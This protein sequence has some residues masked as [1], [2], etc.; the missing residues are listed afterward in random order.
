MTFPSK[1][2]GEFRH[3]QLGQVKDALSAQADRLEVD[4]ENRKKAVLG[5][6]KLYST[7]RI[8]ADYISVPLSIIIGNP[9]IENFF[10]IKDT[11]TRNDAEFIQFLKDNLGKIYNVDAQQYNNDRADLIKEKV[12]FL[13]CS[14]LT[15]AFAMLKYK[16]YKFHIFNELFN[17][18]LNAV[19]TKTKISYLSL[20]ND[21]IIQNEISPLKISI[22]KPDALNKLTD[23]YFNAN[24]KIFISYILI[25][26]RLIFMQSSVGHKIPIRNKYVEDIK[27][28]LIPPNKEINSP[29]VLNILIS[30]VLKIDCNIP[31]PK[32]I[33][34]YSIT[35]E[36]LMK[37]TIWSFFFPEAN[38]INYSEWMSHSLLDTLLGKVKFKAKAKINGKPADQAVKQAK[39]LMEKEYVNVNTALRLDA[40]KN[41]ME[42]KDKCKDIDKSTP[43]FEKFKSYLDDIAIVR[44]LIENL[45]P[46]LSTIVIGVPFLG[47]ILAW[48]KFAMAMSEGVGSGFARNAETK[49]HAGMV[50]EA[51]R[52]ITSAKFVEYDE[53]DLMKLEFILTI[54]ENSFATGYNLAPASAELL[55][56]YNTH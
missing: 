19:D 10:N 15:I 55:S 2:Q 33:I 7:S 30:I 22:E 9:E 29:D 54:R 24:S 39:N 26:Q 53:N 14:A 6:F 5:F 18:V 45:T 47:T 3:D 25:I 32:I 23:E 56:D 17:K 49:T 31:E 37:E 43:S 51:G 34:D 21:V 8:P 48:G 4:N 28:I 20:F 46:D 38:P 27:H 44:G 13:S 11:T 40:F 36:A 1:T 16:T 42:L 52:T 41:E 12:I 35:N 50:A